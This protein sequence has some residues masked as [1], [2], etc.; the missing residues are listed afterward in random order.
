M[1]ARAGRA[2]AITSVVA[3]LYTLF[4]IL[5]GAFVRVT[6]SG[7]GCGQHWP[8]CNGNIVPRSDALET[9]IE[10]THRATSGIC[11][12]VIVAL[13]LIA[14]V[15]F[16]P[17]HRA[18]LG[19][20]LSLVFIIIEALVGASI[21]LLEYVA[22][23]DSV[24]RA[25][26]MAAHLLN[27]YLLS[28][29]LFM[30]WWWGK[31]DR[32]VHLRAPS[33][34]RSFLLLASLGIALVSMTGAITALGDTLYPI[35]EG[36]PLTDRIT[37][38]WMGGHY[39]ARLRVVHPILACTVALYL[40]TAPWNVRGDR[41]RGAAIFVSCAAVVQVSFGA[42][43]VALSA[44]AAMQLGHLFLGL[45]LWLGIVNF[46]AETLSDPE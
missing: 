20:K 19:A 23:N 10:V 16:P 35:A 32:A 39:L 17:G 36:T 3:G 44:P 24:A 34:A 11:M 41:A 2:Y 8:T 14:R 38:G 1:R 25:G 13:Y 40:I 26:W 12:L 5:W 4:V 28:G 22:D 30:A 29:A 46:A 27:T 37:G 43:N 33:P 7:A 9:L 45:V 31:A 15:A 42:A 6:G 21:V 18:R